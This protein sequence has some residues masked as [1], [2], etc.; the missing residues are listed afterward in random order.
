L[1]KGVVVLEERSLEREKDGVETKV[2]ACGEK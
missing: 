2:E 1:G